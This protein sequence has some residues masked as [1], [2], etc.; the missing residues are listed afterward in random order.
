[1]SNELVPSLS[2]NLVEKSLSLCFV[3]DSRKRTY[4]LL[5]RSCL[6]YLDAISVDIRRLLVNNCHLYLV[7]I[8]WD[9]QNSLL[10][11]SQSCISRPCSVTNSCLYL[12]GDS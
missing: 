12:V 6:L 8:L 2:T 4:T 10:L 1:M 7:N 11:N 3:L 9:C 5:E